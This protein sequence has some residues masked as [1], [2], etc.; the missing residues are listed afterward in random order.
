MG[1]EPR[2]GSMRR[3]PAEVTSSRM[4]SSQVPTRDVSEMIATMKDLSLFAQSEVLAKD[5][6]APNMAGMLGPFL[7]REL[8]Y[9]T[10]TL[11]RIQG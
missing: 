3:S 4:R 6:T 2:L 5:E 10:S 11:M 7:D 1:L 9:F 8:G